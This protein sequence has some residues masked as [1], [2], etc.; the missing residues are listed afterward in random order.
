MRNKE[1]DAIKL[2]MFVYESDKYVKKREIGSV[3]LNLSDIC[4]LLRQNKMIEMWRDILPR[5]QVG[6]MTLL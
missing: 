3:K 1:L 5:T 2:E 4:H 6:Y